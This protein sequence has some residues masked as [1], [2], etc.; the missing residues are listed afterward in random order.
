MAYIQALFFNDWR[1][2]PKQG[3]VVQFNEMKDI[4]TL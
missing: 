2:I 4:E 3:D 1:Y